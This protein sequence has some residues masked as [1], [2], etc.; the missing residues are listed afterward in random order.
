MVLPNI[1]PVDAELN[2]LFLVNTT[3]ITDPIKLYKI[4]VIEAG[5]LT[6]RSKPYLIIVD[7]YCTLYDQSGTVIQFDDDTGGKSQFLIAQTLPIGVYFLAVK[8]LSNLT[9]QFLVEVKF[10]TN[11]NP[12][13]IIENLTPVNYQ[14]IPS[15]LLKTLFHVAS[16]EV[17]SPP[18]NPVVIK[19]I[20]S[21]IGTLLPDRLNNVFAIFTSRKSSAL[22]GNAFIA[23]F[24]KEGVTPVIRKVRLYSKDSG[25]FVK[26]V[27]SDNTGAYTFSN[28]PAGMNFFVVSHDSNGIY[29]AVISDNITA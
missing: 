25:A 8:Q 14:Q 5:V 15:N 1:T 2:T 20:T 28:L 19:E 26:E 27:Q 6:V 12:S 22:S 16:K 23:G 7:T 4:S 11:S 24:V 10:V 13:P 3:A 9:S 17:I 29:N 18:R 21:R